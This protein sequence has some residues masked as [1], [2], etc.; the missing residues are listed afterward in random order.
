MVDGGLDYQRY[1]GKDLELV[2]SFCIYSD[3]PHEVIRNYLE[4]G[5]RGEDGK[6][7]LT[8]IKLK[9]IDDD[10]L[11]AIIVYE[12]EHRPN[13]PLLKYFKAEKKWRKKQDKK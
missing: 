6:Q 11:K 13:N 3:E 4:R 2:Q 10:Y 9:D 5:S 8:Y 1:G 12:E 7:P